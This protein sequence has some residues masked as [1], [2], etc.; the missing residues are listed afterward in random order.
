[1]ENAIAELEH[2]HR[3]IQKVITLMSNITR[4]MERGKDCEPALLD[5]VVQFLRIFGEQCHHVKEEKALFSLLETKGVPANGCP[6]AA[7]VGEH[8]RGHVLLNQLQ[9]ASARYKVG[10]GNVRPALINSLQSLVELYTQHIWKEEYLLFP[11][12]H[13]V[14]AAGDHET[15]SRQF[16]AV[17]AQ[18]GFDVHNAMEAMIDSIGQTETERPEEDDQVPSPECS[19]CGS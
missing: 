11:M 14:L 5:E 15:L 18:I 3:E 12:A 13:K 1:M 2:E 19:V 4:E 7:L 8:R 6:I 10:D 16:A 9:A 17:E